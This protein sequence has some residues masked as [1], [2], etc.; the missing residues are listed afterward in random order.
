MLYI[1][2]FCCFSVKDGEFRTYRGHRDEKALVSFVDDK[3]WQEMDAMSWYR[4]PG[5]MQ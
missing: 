1:A 2:H 3:K 5:S 4:S